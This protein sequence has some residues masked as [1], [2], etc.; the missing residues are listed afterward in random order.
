MN[1]KRVLS[2]LLAMAMVFSMMP[3]VTFAKKADYYK[4][5][6]GAELTLKEEDPQGTIKHYFKGNKSKTAR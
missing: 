5:A 1:V 6:C 2:L 4:C 3:M